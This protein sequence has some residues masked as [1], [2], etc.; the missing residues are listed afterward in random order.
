[1]PVAL[2]W[3]CSNKAVGLPPCGVRCLLPKACAALE[4][5]T[6][7]QN[8]GAPDLEKYPCTCRGTSITRT[9][10]TRRRAT[11]QG[12][13]SHND[14][15]GLG[16][17][18]ERGIPGHAFRLVSKRGTQELCSATMH[19]TSLRRQAPCEYAILG[20]L[21]IRPK[22]RHNTAV[23]LGALLPGHP[24]SPFARGPSRTRSSHTA[25][26]LLIIPR[27]SF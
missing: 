6:C 19:C 12:Y 1:M 7:T 14:P 17:S 24:W 27:G 3:S 25:G 26:G 23:T 2:W 16:V 20:T 10:L 22:S 11:V 5:V 13:L 8:T 4:T 21:M 9:R 18:Y 15:R